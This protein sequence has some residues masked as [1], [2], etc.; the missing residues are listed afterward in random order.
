[1]RKIAT[2]LAALA[3]TATSFGLGVAYGSY[4]T[5]AAPTG[6]ALQQV[7]GNGYEVIYDPSTDTYT[8]EPR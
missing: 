7:A 8:I 4:S 3:F 5:Y 6:V 2:V 1:M